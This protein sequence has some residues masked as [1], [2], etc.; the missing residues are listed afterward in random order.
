M[1]VGIILCL[2][3]NKSPDRAMG[4]SLY[5]MRPVAA[6]YSMDRGAKCWVTIL[7]QRTDRMLLQEIF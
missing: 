1:I 5:W 3:L 2:S 7:S 4:T 6:V